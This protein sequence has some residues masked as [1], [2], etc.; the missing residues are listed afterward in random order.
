MNYSQN[1][2][3][4]IGFIVIVLILFI[5]FFAGLW[6]I[7]DPFIDGRYH[8]NWGPPFWLMNA[9]ATNEAGL[10]KSYFG[11]VR[12]YEMPTDGQKAKISYYASHPELIGPAF[13]LWTRIFGY[14]EWSPRIFTLLL[15]MATTL[16]LFTAFYKSFGL[17]F[18][19]IF[20]ALF[21]ALPLIYIYGK[22][23]DPVAL[24]LF[25]LSVTLVGFVKILLKEKN[26]PIILIGG[27]FAMGLS[28]WSG[29]VFGGLIFIL[30]ICLLKHIAA[31]SKI[32][33]PFI[34]GAIILSLL[35]FFIQIYLQSGQPPLNSLIDNYAGLWKYRAGIGANDQ[36]SW[37]DYFWSQIY[38]FKDNFTLP[39][40]LSGIIGLFIA[41]YIELK[42]RDN[43]VKIGTTLF[44]LSVFI[45]ELAY[46]IFLKQG[47]MRHIYYQYYFA[48]PFAFGNIYLLQWC[49]MNFF[50]DKK[51][52]RA[53]IIAGSAIIL[54]AGWRSYKVYTSLLFQD[55]WGDRSDIELIKT[56]KNVPTTDKIVVADNKSAI[57][58]FSNPNIE[59][60]A[61]RTLETRLIG[62]EPEAPYYIIPISNVDAKL[63]QLNSYK[64]NKSDIAATQLCSKHFCLIK[65][66]PQNLHTPLQN[67]MPENYSIKNIEIKKF[68]DEIYG[69]SFE[70]P[71]ILIGGFRELTPELEKSGVKKASFCRHRLIFLIER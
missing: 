45:G 50:S 31:K 39:L 8:Y 47:S 67:S 24:V 55:M 1:S 52:V 20:S 38:Y 54:F 12:N 34:A 29:F 49:I 32:I 3:F 36:I 2:K 58:W 35:I 30:L 25:F 15:T 13:A 6:H 40:V 5:Q 57:E 46:M 23:L 53:F 7:T 43:I 51:I 4:S 44:V 9:K 69:Y 18:A 59:Y 65:N 42:K 26:A 48:V 68:S 22:M 16:L 19:S 61:G 56:L 27:I 10:L 37:F 62:T 28:D 41:A 60:Y 64:Q 21:I 63:S 33:M 14:S 71:D 70:Y 66:I 11:I 17:L